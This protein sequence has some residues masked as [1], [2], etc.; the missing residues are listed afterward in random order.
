MD[1]QPIFSCQ[2]CGSADSRPWLRGCPDYYLR[3]NHSIDYVECTVCSLVQAYPRPTD[4]GA[5]Y[6][7]YPIHV[8]RNRAQRIA[9]RLLLQNV[10]FRPPR[11]LPTSMLLDYGCGDGTYLREIR[12]R[13]KGVC[14]YEPGASQAADVARRLGVPVYSDRA[15]MGADLAG[16]V[17]ILT[18]H[19]V[20]EHVDDLHHAFRNFRLL[21]KP[22]GCLYGVVPNIRSWEARWFQKRWHGLDAPRHLVFPEKRHFVQLAK[23]HGFDR[24]HF[25]YAAF[26]NTLAGSLATVL[27]GH[28]HP[29]LM[30]A[31]GLPC[32]LLSMLAPQGT[33][34]FC[35][36]KSDGQPFP[37][38]TARNGPA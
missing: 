38:P 33:L 19:F 28:F 11:G 3:S 17:D 21:L 37:S 26:P 18:A 1:H 23:D 4:I 25:S 30:I 9:R 7:G 24:L 16:T 20:L 36:F 12:S 5:L 35:M 14:G 2:L 8:P 27:A 15:P 13:F 34:C 31:L 22:G 6:E 32:F 10:Y 29:I